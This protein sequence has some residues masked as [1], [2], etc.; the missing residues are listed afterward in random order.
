VI[1]AIPVVRP[2]YNWDLLGYSGNVYLLSGMSPEAAHARVYSDV[3]ALG[4]TGARF[5]L[6]ADPAT[7]AATRKNDQTSFLEYLPFYSTRIAYIGAAFLLHRLGLSV[8]HSL[9]LISSLSFFTV[10][11]IVLRWVRQCLSPVHSLLFAALTMLA[12]LDIAKEETPDMMSCALLLFGCYWIAKEKPLYGLVIIA[13]SILVRTDNIVILGVLTAFLWR[14]GRLRL[15]PAA[16]LCTVSVGSVG[17]INH[18]SGTYGWQLL[19]QQSFYGPFAHPAEIVPHVTWGMYAHI[20]LGSLATL[21]RGGPYLILLVVFALESKSPLRHLVRAI[22]FASGVHFILFPNADLRYYVLLICVAWVTC[23]TVLSD[24]RGK[25]IRTVG[26]S[27]RAS[28]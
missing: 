15:V 20:A 26:S 2:T 19:F 25:Q 14:S 5:R 10:G 1:A 12:L 3:A 6:A 4:D 27:F 24:N 13:S 21:V 22:L 8:F 28:R 9:M 18:F 11:L 16:I 7:G 17:L 23:A